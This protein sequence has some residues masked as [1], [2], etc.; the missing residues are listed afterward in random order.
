MV[1]N[2]WNLLDVDAML[3]FLENLCL[4]LHPEKGKRPRGG[5]YQKQAV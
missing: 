4:V 1:W 3:E 2:Y 5:G